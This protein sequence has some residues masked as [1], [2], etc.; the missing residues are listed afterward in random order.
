MWNK[1]SDFK[2]PSYP[3]NQ[4]Q[5]ENIMTRLG[6]AFMFQMLEE[7]EKRILVDAMQVVT[8]KAG[9]TIIK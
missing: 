8:F 4:D 7:Q 2:P 3:K 6:Q 9:D 5:K 1:K